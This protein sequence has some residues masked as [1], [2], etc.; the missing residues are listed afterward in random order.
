MKF[1]DDK[2]TKYGRTVHD[3]VKTW[4]GNQYKFKT[5]SQGIYFIASYDAHILYISMML[6][7]MFG[8]KNPTH[9]TID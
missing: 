8:N 7:I 4:W 5:D 1:E 3:I 2:C 9:F 6:C